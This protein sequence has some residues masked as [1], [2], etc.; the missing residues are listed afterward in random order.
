MA[1]SMYAQRLKTVLYRHP[2][3][4]QATATTPSMMSQGVHNSKS[5]H[6]R[7][8]KAP[9]KVDSTIEPLVPHKLA[10]VSEIPGERQHHDHAAAASFKAGS[11]KSVT[12]EL[13]LDAENRNEARLSQVCQR[14]VAECS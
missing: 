12:V 10:R 13:R 7:V 1:R 14:Q 6:K 8:R 9:T 5:Q 11:V 3:H 4:D 2:G